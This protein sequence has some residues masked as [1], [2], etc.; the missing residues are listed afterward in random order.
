MNAECEVFNLLAQDSLARFK[1]SAAFLNFIDPIKSGVRQSVKVRTLMHAHQC[2]L[3]FSLSCSHYLVCCF[4]TWQVG[5]G[6][7]APLASHEPHDR[8]GP[9]HLRASSAG[10]GAAALQRPHG[11]VGLQLTSSRTTAS[12]S[13][14]ASSAP[15]R[16]ASSP[17]PP[18]SSSNPVPAP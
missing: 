3:S 16:T 14:A 15:Q 1:K 9:G 13:T 6:A 2:T 18:F 7:L 5:L 8:D 11:G 17:P 12:A 10:A 4:A